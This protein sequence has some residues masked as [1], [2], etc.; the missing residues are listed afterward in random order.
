MSSTKHAR[1]LDTM[2]DTVDLKIR[3][4]AFIVLTPGLFSPPLEI[5]R[6]DEIPPNYD[7]KK[8][9]RKYTQNTPTL[10]RKTGAA[11]IALTAYRRFDDNQ[12]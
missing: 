2:L 12:L 6:A 4:P 3:H 7:M 8:L 11:N 1:G 10:E 9:Y 5:R